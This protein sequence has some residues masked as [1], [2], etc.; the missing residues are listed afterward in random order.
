MAGAA[1]RQA[2]DARYASRQDRNA[3][4]KRGG[5]AIR[6]ENTTADALA[7]Q[8]MALKIDSTIDTL[9]MDFDLMRSALVNL[10]DN[11]R[12]ASEDGGRIEIHA[13]DN[14]IEVTDH[15]KGIPQEEISRIT[16]PFYMVD[17]SRNKKN[18][19]S[20]LG[21]ALVAR[22]AQVHGAQFAIHSVLGE[23]TTMRI[24]FNPCK[25]RRGEALT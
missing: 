11:A 14:T 15:G 19:D 13:Y 3:G 10:A 2:D 22:I 5:T 25:E 6:C 18:G 7:R 16:E 20:G 4:G 8:N 21:L 9:P 12:K 24:T 23:G 1:L 17:R